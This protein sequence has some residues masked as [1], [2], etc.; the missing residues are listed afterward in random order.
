MTITMK[1]SANASA[2]PPSGSLAKRLLILAALFPLG[3]LLNS[4]RRKR[5]A[6]L[7][8]AAGALLLSSAVSCSSGGSGGT[9][10]GTTGG[11]GASGGSNTYSLTV[12]AT[13]NSTGLSRT[14]GTVNVAVT[15]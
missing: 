2:R 7:S 12:T 9:G 6:L 4:P 1:P 5:N 11:G 8:I 14:L 10:G 3:F 13:F 15:H